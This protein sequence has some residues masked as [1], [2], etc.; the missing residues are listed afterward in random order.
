M[1]PTIMTTAMNAKMIRNS[2]TSLLS[3]WTIDGVV[4]GLGST[5][6]R[7]VASLT[8]SLNRREGADAEA[9]TPPH[10][11]YWLEDRNEERERP[12]VTG[13]NQRTI[14]TEVPP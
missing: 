6:R 7:N 4:Y 1:S 10:R 3:G 8:H 11:D 9:P 12:T 14:L 13:L 2:I 5:N